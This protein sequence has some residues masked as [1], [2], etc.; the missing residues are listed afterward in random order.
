ME[1]L[2]TPNDHLFRGGNPN[3]NNWDNLPPFLQN[4]KKQDESKYKLPQVYSFYH[5][6]EGYHQSM[7]PFEHHF[8]DRRV[9]LYHTPA[10][11]EY[12]NAPEISSYSGGESDEPKLTSYADQAP[13]IQEM[14]RVTEMIPKPGRSSE[15]EISENGEQRVVG[16]RDVSE[17]EIPWQVREKFQN[18]TY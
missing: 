6:M 11:F 16:G 5:K 9:P 18:F 8:Y 4:D 2:D 13:N 12:S 14:N 3:M 7:D 1:G 17:G 15:S 10:S